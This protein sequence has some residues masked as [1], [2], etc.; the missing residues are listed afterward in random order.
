MCIIAAGFT[1]SLVYGGRDIVF[2]GS[3]HCVASLKSEQPDSFERESVLGLVEI[4]NTKMIG[5]GNASALSGGIGRRYEGHVVEEIVD[6]QLIVGFDEPYAQC[7]VYLA[8]P[9]HIPSSSVH[10]DTTR[11]EQRA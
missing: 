5:F 11:E 2:A 6:L 7:I 10:G 3:F 1:R 8:I 4:V 9:V